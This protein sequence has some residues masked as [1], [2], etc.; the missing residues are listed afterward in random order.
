MT[1]ITPD[2]AATWD[3]DVLSTLET[4][5]ST[6]SV[7]VS[8][9]VTT[10]RA[11]ANYRNVGM[12]PRLLNEGFFVNRNCLVHYELQLRTVRVRPLTCNCNTRTRTPSMDSTNSYVPS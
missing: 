3:P 5:T 7:T 11:S 8:H 4:V 10:V 2:T 6:R 12:D 1:T 9:T